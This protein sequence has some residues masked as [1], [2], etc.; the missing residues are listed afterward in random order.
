A[1]EQ[2]AA[3]TPLHPALEPLLKSVIQSW[4]RQS[5]PYADLHE[6]TGADAKIFR[7]LFCYPPHRRLWEQH[8]RAHA[9]LCDTG[10]DP[11]SADAYSTRHPYVAILAQ[12]ALACPLGALKSLPS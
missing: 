5:S 9:N 12:Y 10:T 1:F 2:V 4:V 11:A 7:Y 6:I 8:L 3:I